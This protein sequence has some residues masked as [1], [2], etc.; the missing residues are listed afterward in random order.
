MDTL[1]FFDFISNV[2]VK[3]ARKMSR[4]IRR[5][6][7]ISKTAYH[8]WVRGWCIPKVH[9]RIIINTVAE[10]FGYKSVYYIG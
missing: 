4:E 9:N 6:C 3:D 7:Q 2:R 8:K 5:E 1:V 10:S